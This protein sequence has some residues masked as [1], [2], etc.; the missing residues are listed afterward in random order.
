MRLNTKGANNMMT[1]TTRNI[2]VGLVM[3]KRCVISLNIDMIPYF[4][5]KYNKNNN[6]SSD[7][8]FFTDVKTTFKLQPLSFY[9]FFLFFLKLIYIK[10]KESVFQAIEMVKMKKSAEGTKADGEIVDF[11]IHSIELFRNLNKRKQTYAKQQ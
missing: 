11:C 3:G 2:Q 6:L 5:Q 1:S 8:H 4:V 7:T 10:K 9:L